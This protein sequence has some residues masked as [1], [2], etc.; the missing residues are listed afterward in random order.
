MLGRILNRIGYVDFAT[1]V[2]DAEGRISCWQG[3]INKCN[4]GQRRRGSEAAVEDIDAPRA[5]VSC[6]KQIVSGVDG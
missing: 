2:I 3:R 1:D 4:R 5:E 6:V